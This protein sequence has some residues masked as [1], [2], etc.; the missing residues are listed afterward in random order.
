MTLLLTWWKLLPY[1]RRCC[2]SSEMLWVLQV[3]EKLELC[4]VTED[5]LSWVHGIGRPAESGNDVEI[6]CRAALGALNTGATS[7]DADSM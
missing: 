5:E 6:T 3:I 1:W 2:S 4:R 7:Q